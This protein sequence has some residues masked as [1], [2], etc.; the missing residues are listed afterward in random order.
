MT[1][2]HLIVLMAFVLLG[3]MGLSAAQA[4]LATCI[5]QLIKRDD[6]PLTHLDK[7]A[8]IANKLPVN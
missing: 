1:A 8:N 4:G 7:Q 6:K 3:G 2:S 5:R